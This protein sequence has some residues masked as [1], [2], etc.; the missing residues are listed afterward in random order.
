M[1]KKKDNMPSLQK[2]KHFFILHQFKLFQEIIEALLGIMGNRVFFFFFFFFFFLVVGGGGL[3]PFQEY[4]TY[5]EPIVHQ[6]WANSGEPG[7]KTKK[8]LTIRKQNFAF[9]HVTPARLEPQC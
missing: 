4:F 8:H 5:I 7:K 9:T 1:E 2:Q 3:H 6:R